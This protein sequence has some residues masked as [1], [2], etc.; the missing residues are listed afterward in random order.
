MIQA[1]G[2]QEGYYCW[3]KTTTTTMLGNKVWSGYFGGKN[4]TSFPEF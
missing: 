1:Q 2:C 4:I 3:Y